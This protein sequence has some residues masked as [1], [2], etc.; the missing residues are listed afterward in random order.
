MTKAQGTEALIT[1]DGREVAYHWQ[2]S[3]RRTMS[4]IIDQEQGVVVRTPNR[5]PRRAVEGFLREKSRWIRRHLDNL[6][7]RKSRRTPRQWIEGETLPF[8]DSHLT[9]AIHH[10]G[11]R[12]SA[13]R[14]NERLL[15][16]LPTTT[17]IPMARAVQDIVEDWYRAQAQELFQARVTAFQP[18]LGVQAKRVRVRN[19]K[20]RWGSCSARGWLNFNWRLLLAPSQVL[21]YV[22]VHELA[23]LRELNH[24]PRFWSL[25]SAV[26]PEHTQW[27]TWL[28]RYGDTLTLDHQI[29]AGVPVVPLSAPSASGIQEPTGIPN[30][31][32]GRLAPVQPTENRDA[33]A[34]AALPEQLE[35]SL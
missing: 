8:L 32:A 10:N 22:V 24:S 18:Q 13:V 34:K 21:D 23:H 3:H 12:S 14:E 20:R 35:M 31:P 5:T 7:V 1:L 11:A 9:L 15:V 2:R 33:A 26:M 6:A 16:S 17:D 25:V 30:L 29:T 19:Q 4:I 27:R 28:R